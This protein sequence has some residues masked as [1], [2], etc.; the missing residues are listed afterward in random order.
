MSKSNQA[1]KRLESY[2][3]K[4]VRDPPSKHQRWILEAQMVI[5]DAIN[6]LKGEGK[7]EN[8]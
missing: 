1:L 8:E 7:L 3:M 5:Q 2:K 6:I 4:S